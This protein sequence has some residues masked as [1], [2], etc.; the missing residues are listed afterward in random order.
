[1]SK[2]DALSKTLVTRNST[3]VSIDSEELVVGDLITILEGEVIP[4]DCLIVSNHDLESK[5][6][7]Q[8]SICKLK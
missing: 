6:L 3:Q 2:S 7:Q 5:V 8:G 1:M 4:A